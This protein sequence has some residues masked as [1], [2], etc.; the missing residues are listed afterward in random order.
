MIKPKKIGV[1]KYV[2]IRWWWSSRNQRRDRQG[3]KW[4]DNG[5]DN[6]CY[7]IVVVRQSGPLLSSKSSRLSYS[8]RNDE[9]SYL[10]F[11]RLDKREQSA[12]SSCAAPRVESAT[13]RD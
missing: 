5:N 7:Y 12:G 10:V 2:Y 8:Q 4:S 1:D 13:P 11:I 3:G 9:R 6:D